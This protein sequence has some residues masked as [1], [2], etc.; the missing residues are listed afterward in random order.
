MT[1]ELGFEGGTGGGHLRVQKWKS[2][3][4]R[5]PGAGVPR[6]AGKGPDA[7]EEEHAEG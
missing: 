3:E 7:S 6:M 1:F 4:T 5:W 2:P